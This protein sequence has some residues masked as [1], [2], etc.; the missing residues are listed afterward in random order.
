MG[1]PPVASAGNGFASHSSMAEADRADARLVETGVLSGS[2]SIGVASPP[3]ANLGM[4]GPA[5]FASVNLPSPPSVNLGMGSPAGF[6]SVNLPSPPSVNFGPH[7]QGGSATVFSFKGVVSP[8]N[9][10]KWVSVPAVVGTAKTGVINRS[11]TPDYPRRE[12]SPGATGATSPH[13][14]YPLT[15]RSPRNVSPDAPQRQITPGPWATPLTVG[16]PNFSKASAYR[17]VSPAAPSSRVMATTTP[18]KVIY[19]GG[20]VPSRT[21]TLK[22]AVE[23]F[24][25]L[26]PPRA[27]P[28][29]QQNGHACADKTSETPGTP[30]P[31]DKE[32]VEPPI[33]SDKL[34]EAAKVEPPRSSDQ[35][36]E[37]FRRA[38]R[39]LSGVHLLSGVG[40]PRSPDS[41]PAQGTVDFLSPVVTNDQDRDLGHLEP[42]VLTTV[43]RIGEHLRDRSKLKDDVIKFYSEAANAQSE[44]KEDE[45]DKQENGS[46]KVQDAVFDMGLT[47]F[48]LL[49]FIDEFSRHLDIP[50]FAFGNAEESF[51]QFDFNGQG[52]LNVNETYKL[53]KFHLDKYRF[54]L[55]GAPTTVEIP[56]HSPI[57]LGY[58]I[59]KEIGKGSQGI[60]KLTRDASNREMCM[61]VYYKERLNQSGVQ[62]LI[63]EFS[64]MNMLSCKR[65]AGVHALFQDDDFYYMAC[66]LHR[67][68]D[69]NTITERAAK[70]EVA[71]TK[72]WWRNIWKQCIEGLAF[73]HEQAIMHCDIKEG[74]IM[75]KTEDFAE[76]EIVIIDLGVSMSFK[77]AEGGISGT[78]GY[79]P[80]E[81]LRDM[82]WYPRGDIFSLGVAIFQVMCSMHPPESGTFLVGCTTALDVFKATLEREP[83]WDRFPDQFPALKEMVA[84]ML[85]KERMMR[86]R[87]PQLLVNDWFTM[88]KLEE[89]GVVPVTFGQQGTVNKEEF[90]AILR[91]TNHFATMGITREMVENLSAKFRQRSKTAWS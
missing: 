27:L 66:N 25:V 9:S 22:A 75:L 20:A 77:E 83:E 55:G 67:G 39:R 38:S 36:K 88:E 57:D 2:C 31:K 24:D 91:P 11:R 41:S 43:E 69:L 59:I 81:T 50:P 82:K 21:S 48:G 6:A 52:R 78:P 62:D 58:S 47:Q 4:S 40:L 84:S 8:R 16:T 33:S 71:M 46:P 3:S 90:Y 53:V 61:K 80:P 86:P 85:E 72:D 1:P 29:S 60:A 65:I 70:Q 73:M 63:S 34:E 35:L 56:W 10:A 37:A 15:H 44:S 12:L 42:H 17:T 76:P 68:G 49:L 7:I 19:P 79:V 32:M 74:N 64:T 13:V 26:P 14:G 23:K 89:E 51:I 54:D 28:P 87:A 5:G 45:S 30:A 18:A